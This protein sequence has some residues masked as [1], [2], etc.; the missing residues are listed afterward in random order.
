[1]G[2]WKASMPMK[3]MDQM[4]R[5]MAHPPPSSHSTLMRG[6]GAVV[7]RLAMSS[8]VNDARMAT[9]SETTTNHGV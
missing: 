4:P 7:T 5:P 8:A 1:M 6:V 9:T 2:V 3:C